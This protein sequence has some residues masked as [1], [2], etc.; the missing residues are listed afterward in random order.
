MKQRIEKMDL[1]DKTV[2]VRCDYN[3]PI[4]NEKILDDTKIVA[5]LETI[6]YLMKNNCKIILL[7]HLGK[8]KTEEDKLFYSLEPVS[9][10]LKELVGREVYFSHEILDPELP[11]RIE[12]MLPR[13]ILLLENTRFLDV[14]NLLEKN[15]DAQVS[16]FFASLGDVFVMDAFASAHRSHASVVGI[17]KYIPSCIGF[18]VERELASLDRFLKTPEHPFTVIMGG[19]KVEDKLEL[20]STL[21][22]KCDYLLLA[23]GLANSFLKALNFNIGSSLATESSKTLE[24]LK[25][26]MLEFRDKLMLPLDAIVGSTYEKSYTRY[27]RINEIGDNEVIMDIG[28][29]TLEKYKTAIKN[30]KTIFLNGTMGKYEDARFSNGTKELLNILKNQDAVVVVGGGDAA[31]AV[32]TFGFQE[33]LTYLSVGGGATLEYLVKGHLVGIDAIME[34]KRDD[35]EVLDV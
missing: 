27:K 24:T 15:C 14:P 33:E 32:R 5:S 13:D 4:Y 9:K 30:S 2:I 16:S 19:A 17:S 31:S 29:K 26:I 20:I 25:K 23:G 22:P 1:K 34:E 8:V 28:I 35:I 21:L 7:S 12:L 6:R 3:V 10:R 18:S 11:K